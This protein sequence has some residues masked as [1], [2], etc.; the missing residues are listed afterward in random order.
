[1]GFA[2]DLFGTGKTVLRGGYGMYRFHDE[3]NV[4]AAAL[5]I[6]QGA[7]GVTLNN[8]TFASIASNSAGFTRPGGITVLGGND[9]EE[10]MTQS[11]SFTIA[12]RMPGASLFEV[13]YVGNSSSDLSNWN[14]NLGQLNDIP[15]GTVFKIPGFFATNGFSPSTGSTDALRPYPLYSGTS[16]IKEINH[17]MYSNYNSL[18]ASWNKQSGHINYLLNYTFSKALGVRGEG[19]GPGN[20]DPLSLTNDYGVLPNDRTHIFNVAYV[21][22]IP[23]W[24]TSNKFASGAVNG[25]KLSGISQ[26][27]SG[28]N[29]QASVTGNFNV[30][31]FLPT[32]TVLPDGTTITPAYVAA[33]GP[34]GISSVL[35]TGS[36]DIPLNPILTCD[37]SKGLAA[38]QY[39]NPNCFAPPTP[40]HNGPVVMPY[41]KGPAFFNNDLSFFKDFNIGEHQKIQFRM[42]G[43]N[44][45]NHPLTSFIS[46]DNNFNLN[47]G[48]NGKVSNTTFGDA[49]W[50]TGHRIVQFA[51]KYNF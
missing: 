9:D 35:I 15:G 22:E 49:V 40:G 29:I 8:Q 28:V 16:S 2:L 26:F 30:S 4:Q 11:Y 36:P 34:V 50:T 37:P 44:F 31:G 48:A 6:P 32:G 13:A 5:Q 21:I 12:Q 25:W 43:Y 41:I 23:K 27:Q 7:Y 1:V 46:G 38:G 33:N 14:N 45:L 42:S 18:Q 10:P 51:L 47:F 17:Q 19:G 24:K 3:Q 39:I 20:L